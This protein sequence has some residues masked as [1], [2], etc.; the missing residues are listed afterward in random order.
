MELIFFDERTPVMRG[1]LR[2][3]QYSIHTS[4]YFI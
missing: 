4:I 1:Q 3:E 2:L